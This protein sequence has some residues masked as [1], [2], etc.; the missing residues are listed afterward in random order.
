MRSLK[1]FIKAFVNNIE[2]II[3]FEGI[4][5][6][7][8]FFNAFGALSFVAERN[9]TT[10]WRPQVLLHLTFCLTTLCTYVYSSTMSG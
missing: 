4:L 10:W 9:H 7:A 5:S 1:S 3:T 6:D 2:L 8:Y